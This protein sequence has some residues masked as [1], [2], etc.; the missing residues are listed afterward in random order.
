MARTRDICAESC[1]RHLT[2]L[3]P[4]PNCPTYLWAIIRGSSRAINLDYW[5]FAAQAKAGGALQRL[6]KANV[7]VNVK[8]VFSSGERTFPRAASTFSGAFSAQ[9]RV[10]APGESAAHL[11]NI[12]LPALYSNWSLVPSCAAQSSALALANAPLALWNRLLSR[13]PLVP[14]RRPRADPARRLMLH[15]FRATLGRIQRAKLFRRFWPA[16]TSRLASEIMSKSILR[17]VSFFLVD[18]IRIRHRGICCRHSGWEVDGFTLGSTSVNATGGG[19]N[20]RLLDPGP[21]IHPDAS[22]SNGEY[23]SRATTGFA[24][25][26]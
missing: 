13:R 19:G 8:W 20:P 26:S 9:A 17:R 2:L 25:S 10:L 24:P 3:Y 23:S 22:M 14:R 16:L 11:A 21:L 7:A 18:A 4:P 12:T 6:K 5:Q 15:N 1:I